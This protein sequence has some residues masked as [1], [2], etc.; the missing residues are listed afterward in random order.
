MR[1]FGVSRS[2]LL[3]LFLMLGAIFGG[4]IGDLITSMNISGTVPLLTKQFVIFDIQNIHINLYVL[5]FTFSVVFAPNL[6]SLI[7]II[8][9]GYLFRRL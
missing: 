7:G 6:I 8:C 3:I 4:V 2:L 9:A 5:S 1:N